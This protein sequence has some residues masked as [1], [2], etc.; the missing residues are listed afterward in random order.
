[1][2]LQTKRVAKPPAQYNTG[3]ITKLM[4]KYKIGT[5]AT[6]ANIVQTLLDRKFIKLEKNKYIYQQI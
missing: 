5:S 3:N 2:R 1:M 6:T 4:N